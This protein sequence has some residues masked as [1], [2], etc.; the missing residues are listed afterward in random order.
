VFPSL[1]RVSN[2]TLYY[3]RS[4]ALCFAVVSFSD[5]NRKKEGA[6]SSEI[7]TGCELKTSSYE[8]GGEL[9]SNLTFWSWS[10]PDLK[11]AATGL[12]IFLFGVLVGG[13]LMRRRL[14]I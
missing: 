13:V 2:I 3:V 4:F 10:N 1:C 9:K 12:I 6:V 8:P 5:I 11:L 14:G 7:N